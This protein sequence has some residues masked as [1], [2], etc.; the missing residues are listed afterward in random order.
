MANPQTDVL[1]VGSGHAGAQAAIMLRQ[2]KYEGS[3]GIIGAETHLPYERPP[4]SKDY[5]SGEKSFERITIRPQAFWDE[6]AIQ[7][8]LGDAVIAVDANAHQVTTA[9]GAQ[10]GYG[11]LIW[12]TGGEPRRLQLDGADL[13]G[14]HVVRTRDDADAILAE[15]TKARNVAII[16]GGYIGLE[17]AAVISKMGLNVTVI[18]ALPRVL[19]RVA[20]EPLSR[21]IEGEHRDHG[22]TVML[23]AGVSA[24]EGVDGHVTAVRLADGSAVPADII[25][26]GI[27]II[28][29]VE[30]LIAAGAEG[31]LG[32]VLVDSHCR[33]SLPD[34]YAIGDCA[35]HP[36]MFAD[37]AVIRV[38]S[39]QNANDQANMVAHAIMGDAQS[40]GATPWFW[41]NQ[42][43][44][45]LQTVGLNVGYD[46]LVVRGSV[47][48]KSF[49]V[50][51]LKAGK[52]IAL[53]CINAIKDY[54]QGRK[55]VEAGA[56]IA[57]ERL[58]DASVPLKE[59]VGV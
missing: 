20:G 48:D 31:G 27:G 19:A 28:P 25:I 9:S 2:I 22:V 24:F 51:Y 59:M 14:V 38:E 42:Y 58:A 15:V 33:T 47:D 11:T 6:R 46:D 41:S 13:S 43:D 55:L 49:S 12:A 4:L 3:I 29:A 8:H 50:I 39:I 45:K 52:V 54:V 7:F 10:F 30:P 32:G 44:I 16:G 23:D 5:F 34:I 53:D 57:P 26:V 17:A 37:G 40:Y 56:V 18:E 35:A 21:F 36:N 1:I